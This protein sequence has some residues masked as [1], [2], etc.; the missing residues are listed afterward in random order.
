M[1]A[2]VNPRIT[3][4]MVECTEFPDYAAAHSVRAV[5][6]TVINGAVSFEGRVPEK[7]FLQAL[8]QALGK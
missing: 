2:M 8:E 1:A 4:V 6:K 7:Q 3:G 5:P